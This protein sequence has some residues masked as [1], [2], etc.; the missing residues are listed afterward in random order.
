M[1]IVSQWYR[2]VENCTKA[3]ILIAIHENKSVRLCL[4][5]PS[6]AG[7]RGP[8]RSHQTGRKER[9]HTFGWQILEPEPPKTSDLQKAAASLSSHPASL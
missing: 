6:C 3:S 9:G 7:R 8:G 4:R 1:L 2:F 5:Q